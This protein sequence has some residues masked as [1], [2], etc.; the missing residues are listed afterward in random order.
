MNQSSAT[1]NYW[2]CNHSSHITPYSLRQVQPEMSPHIVAVMSLCLIFPVC[3]PVCVRCSVVVYYISWDFL[4]QL[5][6]LIKDC[7]CCISWAVW[8]LPQPLCFHTYETKLYYVFESIPRV[9]FARKTHIGIYRL[10]HWQFILQ[11]SSL[12]Y[13]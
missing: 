1:E 10:L 5:D 11:F 13:L 6:L 4:F 9:L 12:I 8:L 7:F 3:L 2:M